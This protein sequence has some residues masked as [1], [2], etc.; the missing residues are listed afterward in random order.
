[1]R[2]DTTKVRLV[3]SLAA[4]VLCTMPLATAGA[5]SQGDSTPRATGTTKT[6]PGSVEFSGNVGVGTAPAPAT[7]TTDR[8]EVGGRISGTSQ[9]ATA[10]GAG[11]LYGYVHN[12]DPTRYTDP[13]NT[14]DEAPVTGGA[15]I[16]A[17]TS[18]QAVDNTWSGY[19]F[20][21]ASDSSGFVGAGIAGQYPLL[22]QGS[23]ATNLLFLNSDGVNFTEKMR[24]D[25]AGHVGIG[26]QTPA[27]NLEVGAGK[28][29]L[30]D[31]WTVRSSRRFKTNIRPLDGALQ[32]VEELQGVSYD[33][34]D[35]GRH[36]IGVVAEDVAQVVPEVVSRDA[37]T[38]AVE[39]VD[40]SRLAA[41]L[42]EAVKTEQIE[43]RELKAQIEELTSSSAP[44]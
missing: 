6:I 35:T 4:V 14:A 37:N 8:L 36:E 24:I 38:D 5:Q 34:K 29:T 30:A 32:K 19:D 12:T 22:S 9:A 21:S 3:C 11:G 33:R 7:D 2:R 43:I 31:A 20:Q 1:M 15:G 17:R 39:G 27:N 26:T 16:F 40:Y 13:T 41:L 44:H 18:D 23:Y 28:T 10:G 25:S 42:I